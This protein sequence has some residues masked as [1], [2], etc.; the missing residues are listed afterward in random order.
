M[1]RL[2]ISIPEGVPVA[3]FLTNSSNLRDSQA[4]KTKAS[5]KTPLS[6]MFS[7]PSDSAA[8]SSF[9]WEQAQRYLFSCK[10]PRICCIFYAFL[11]VLCFVQKFW[12]LNLIPVAHYP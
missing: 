12:K 1:C 5:Q 4:V 11:F 8:A 6:M 7:R 2:S 10:R 9:A 3:L